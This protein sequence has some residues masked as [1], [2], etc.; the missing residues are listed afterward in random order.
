MVQITLTSEQA[1]QLSGATRPIV[2]VDPGGHRVGQAVPDPG[3]V[4]DFSEEMAA[5]D[6]ATDEDF[7]SFVKGLEQPE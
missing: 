5:W 2:L 3:Q 1:S 6:Q 4:H 7:Q